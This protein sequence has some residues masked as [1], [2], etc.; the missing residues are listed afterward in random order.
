MA[1]K[2]VFSIGC[3]FWAIVLT[4]TIIISKGQCFTEGKTIPGY[5]MTAAL[6]LI[7][8]ILLI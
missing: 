8:I 4:I 7:G 6:Y 2:G 1:I 5:M 3:L